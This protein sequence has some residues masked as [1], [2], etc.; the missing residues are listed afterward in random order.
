[1]VEEVL[2]TRYRVT[3]SDTLVYQ[4]AF[5]ASAAQEWS[6]VTALVYRVLNDGREEEPIRRPDGSPMQFHA[7]TEQSALALA[8][9][10]L[11]AVNG[12]QPRAID[13]CE[14]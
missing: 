8:C 1:M 4:I 10:V 5:T 3:F 14:R 12:T 13:V 9:E 7:P 6:M 2:R 11:Q